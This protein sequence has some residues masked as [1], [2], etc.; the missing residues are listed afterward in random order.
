[1]R[2][3]KTVTGPPPAFTDFRATQDAVVEAI[4]A[5]LN[6]NVTG[7]AKDLQDELR[8]DILNVLGIASAKSALPAMIE[9]AKKIDTM[10]ISNY[11]GVWRWESQSRKFLSENRGVVI[12]SEPFEIRGEKLFFFESPR[13]EPGSREYV[14]WMIYQSLKTAAFCRLRKCPGCPRF[15]VA[16]DT[17]RKYCSDR[18]KDSYNN[19]RRGAGYFTERKRERRQM[20]VERAGRL[21]K[22]GIAVGAVQAKTGLSLTSLRRAGLIQE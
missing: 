21:L 6:Q 16:K 15:F 10:E 20:A 4:A 17:K 2:V 7:E 12:V 1:M 13:A 5:L 19:K 22:S 9:V 14:Y 18:C 8:A 11:L 3:N